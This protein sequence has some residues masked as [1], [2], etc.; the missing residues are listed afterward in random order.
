MAVAMEK[1]AAAGAPA[2]C[3]RGCAACCQQFVGISA[4]EAR[5]IGRLVD[6]MPPERQAV[7]RHRFAETLSVMRANGIMAPQSPDGAPVFLIHD[8][9]KTG[10]ERYADVAQ[11]YFALHRPCPFL[12]DGACSIY[13][14]RPL[15]C[16][17][18]AVT[19]PAELCADLD[20]AAL[21]M[22]VPPVRLS[23]G[24]AELTMLVEDRPAVQIPLFAALAW[25]AIPE[26]AA[27]EPNVSGMELLKLL[28]QWV[29]SQSNVP[30]DQRPASD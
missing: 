3:R 1:T 23:S 22:V 13:E 5:A 21:Q 25:A 29:D 26:N 2:S 19:T 9:S 20:V 15:I 28:A 17:E 30:L 18:Y 27:P 10:R 11:R 6:A 7:I 16:R 12:D 8:H 24:L 14:D 4:P